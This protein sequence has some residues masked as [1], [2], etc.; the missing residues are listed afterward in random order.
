MTSIHTT[1]KS[2][3]KTR[4]MVDMSGSD[5]VNAVTAKFR[6]AITELT[7]GKFCKNL[8]FEPFYCHLRDYTTK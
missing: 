5:K 3:R 7:C 2:D 6:S 4:S 8:E 1:E